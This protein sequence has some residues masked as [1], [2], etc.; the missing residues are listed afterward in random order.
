MIYKIT[1]NLP[2]WFKGNLYIYTQDELYLV[3]KIKVPLTEE[4]KI[5][6]FVFDSMK[7][8]FK[9]SKD[10]EVKK[11]RKVWMIWEFVQNIENIFSDEDI[12]NVLTWFTASDELK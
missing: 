5:F 8:E 3:A 10:K 11:A 4:K 7:D 12:E 6:T 9:N 1:D 2:V